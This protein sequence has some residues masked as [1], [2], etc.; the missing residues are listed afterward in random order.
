MTQEQLFTELKRAGFPVAYNSFDD[1][2]DLPKPPY[3][4]YL[5]IESDN[6]SS[7]EK[8]HGK[9]QNYHVEL[10][11]VK[12]DPVSEKKLEDILGIIDPEYETTEVYI[13]SERLLQVTYSIT[14]FE[15]VGK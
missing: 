7:D 4:V 9:F 3:V 5:R 6:V 10:Y 8:V 11:T 2:H 14:I 1:K 12:R 13:D 15:K